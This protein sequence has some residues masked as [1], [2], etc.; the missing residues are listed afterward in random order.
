MYN[1]LFAD[2]VLEGIRRELQDHT[3][4]LRERVKYYMET[5]GDRSK[6]MAN[7]NGDNKEINMK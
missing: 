3:N 6:V 7:I 4:R 5:N 1:L 2:I